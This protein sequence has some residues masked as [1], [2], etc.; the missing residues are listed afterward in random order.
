MASITP[1]SA[2]PEPASAV[3]R[4]PWLV[5]GRALLAAFAL[6]LGQL[7][8]GTAQAVN[9]EVEEASTRLYNETYE[10]D[11][12]IDYR[13]SEEVLQALNNGVPLTL[14][15]EIEVVRSRRY[16]VDETVTTLEQRFQLTYH[17]FSDQY[18]LRDLNNGELTIYPSL[19]M[20]IDSLGSLQGL[21]LLTAA[22]VLSD[23]EYQVRLRTLL[24]IEALPAP[25]RPVAYVTPA[26]RLASE[27]FTCSLTP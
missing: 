23:H 16:W 5:H 20:A 19:T 6:G 9:F 7:Y 21:P 22:E 24:D 15:T 10:L 1:A 14:R 25:L 11:A 4:A 2:R 27:W 26:W 8:A 3:S 18:L 13:F 12:R 17:A